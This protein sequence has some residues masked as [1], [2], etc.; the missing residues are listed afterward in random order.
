[1]IRLNTGYEET[2]Y[3]TD[4]WNREGNKIRGANS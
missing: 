2:L 3:H 4:W 1:L